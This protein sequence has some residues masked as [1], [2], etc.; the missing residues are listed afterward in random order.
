MMP[1]RK[2]NPSGE[3]S[4]RRRAACTGHDPELWFPKP[5]NPHSTRKE[6]AAAKLRRLEQ[7]TKAKAICATCPVR[8]ECYEHAMNNDVQGIWGGT[9]ETERGRTPLR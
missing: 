9:T 4:W 5:A 3:M 6:A 8:Q 1:T 7:E 2:P